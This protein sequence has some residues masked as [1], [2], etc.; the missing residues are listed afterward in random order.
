MVSSIICAAWSAL[1]SLK[2]CATSCRSHI[3]VVM[4]SFVSVNSFTVYPL[5][6]MFSTFR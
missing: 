6:S 5:V 4:L 3:S 1:A 2:S